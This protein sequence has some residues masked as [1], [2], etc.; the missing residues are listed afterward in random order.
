MG[1]GKTNMSGRH[2]IHGLGKY[3]DD[4]IPAHGAVVGKGVKVDKNNISNSE[5]QVLAG[6]YNSFG[7][8]KVISGGHPKGGF[9]HKSKSM[10]N[11]KD[12]DMKGDQ[13]NTKKDYSMDKGNT[14]PNYKSKKDGESK[15]DQSASDKD[16]SP[17]KTLSKKQSK[18]IDGA[19]GSKKN[20]KIEGSE[21]AALSKK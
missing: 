3:S 9:M 10:G 15:G 17:K 18:V 14:D 8:A 5:K 16:Y 21:I 6:A 2:S 13:S 4:S 19:D 7:Q 11:P 12:G 1:Y 20:D